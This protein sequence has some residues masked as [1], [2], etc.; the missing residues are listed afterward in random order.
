MN[1]DN[2]Q[3]LYDDQSLIKKKIVS[4]FIFISMKC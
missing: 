2:N 4:N 1:V 3:V